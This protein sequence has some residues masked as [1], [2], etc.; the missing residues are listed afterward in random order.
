[1]EQVAWHV[2]RN[3]AIADVSAKCRSPGRHHSRLAVR[4]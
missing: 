2:R 3:L 1:M 4:T